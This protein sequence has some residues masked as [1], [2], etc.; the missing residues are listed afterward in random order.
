MHND[1]RAETAQLQ[2]TN[3][4]GLDPAAG[5][6]EGRFADP[7]T[8]GRRGLLE[9]CRQMDSFAGGIHGL[10][11]AHVQ[12]M[13]DDLARVRTNPQLDVEAGPGQHRVHFERRAA[14]PERV[15]LVGV[16]RT[17]QGHQPIAG[18]AVYRA[19]ITLN[20]V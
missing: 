20:R 14:G 5:E 2:W 8:A 9:A 6:R 4:P 19:A 16:G 15:L 7:G 18:D 1:L 3:D 12:R 17:E 13:H 10:G 11:G